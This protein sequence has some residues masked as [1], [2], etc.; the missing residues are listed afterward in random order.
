MSE[1]K[2]T[3]FPFA[4]AIKNKLLYWLLGI[5]A[6]GAGSWFTMF[7]NQNLFTEEQ[8]TALEK[9]VHDIKHDYFPKEDAQELKD[10]V[11]LMENNMMHQTTQLNKIVEILEK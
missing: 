9:E 8:G 10:R 11:L 1:K 6:V 2:G 3:N 5:V 4:T 7:A